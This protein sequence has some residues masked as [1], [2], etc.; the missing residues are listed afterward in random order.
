MKNVLFFNVFRFDGSFSSKSIPPFNSIFATH[1]A[2]G[3]DVLRI[4]LLQNLWEKKC[5][6][7]KRRMLKNLIWNYSNRKRIQRIF[8]L[9][10]FF[11]SKLWNLIKIDIHRNAKNH[12]DKRWKVNKKMFEFCL[13]KIGARKFGAIGV[14]SITLICSYF[15]CIS[16]I[17]PHIHEC[18]CQ[19]FVDR[20]AVQVFISAP[21][22][23]RYS[24]W[25]QC[26]LR[27]PFQSFICCINMEIKVRT[28]HSHKNDQREFAT[29]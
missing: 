1:K 13:E 16:G 22:C 3:W 26:G 28:L 15:P 29:K 14:W 6:Q 20:Q 17:N 7:P 11:A 9:I 21:L 8:F 5:G 10:Y 12:F 27:M 18:K 19:S 24:V 25:L 4:S 23:F 2:I